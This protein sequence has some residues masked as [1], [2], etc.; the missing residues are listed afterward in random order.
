M[1]A[2]AEEWVFER[3]GLNDMMGLMVLEGLGPFNDQ[4][5]TWMTKNKILSEKMP[6]FPKLLST[7]GGNI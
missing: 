6:V 4:M 3:G 1:R 5:G 7:M 2:G